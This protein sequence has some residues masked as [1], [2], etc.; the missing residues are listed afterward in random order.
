M[1]DDPHQ[2]DQREGVAFVVSITALASVTAV[3]QAHHRP[4]HQGGP[5]NS[6]TIS[7]RPNPVVYF[8]T[9]SI[10]GRYRAD[11]NA[12]QA[13]GLQRDPWPFEGSWVNAGTATTNAR[14]DYSFVHRPRVN[15]RYRTNFAGAIFS[16]NVTVGVRI[17]VSRRVSDRTPEVGERVRFRGRACPQHDGARSVSSGAPAPGGGGRSAAPR[18]GISRVVRALATAGASACSAMAPTGWW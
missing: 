4:G 5:K 15:T 13:I 12:G 11:T 10:F 7:A 1:D 2:G 3:A 17:R 16:V 8:R 9:T 14:G 18:C 6:L